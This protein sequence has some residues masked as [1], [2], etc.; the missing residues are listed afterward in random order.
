M[1]EVFSKRAPGMALVAFCSLA[2]ACFADGFADPL[3]DAVHHFV[4]DKDINGDGKVQLEELRDVR[5]WGSTNFNGYAQ[6]LP[7]A[8][9]SENDY[10][11]ASWSHVLFR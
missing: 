2:A 11:R 6:T 1:I 10:G 8:N 7:S 9:F 5:H 4:F 3:A